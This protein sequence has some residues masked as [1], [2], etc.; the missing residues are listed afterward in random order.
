MVQ[1]SEVLPLLRSRGSST[2]PKE[3]RKSGFSFRVRAA[4]VSLGAASIL[5][6]VAS[7]LNRPE[8]QLEGSSSFS[9]FIVKYPQGNDASLSTGSNIPDWQ[10][11]MRVGSDP[12]SLVL[13]STSCIS[14][15]LPVLRGVDVV[16]YFSLKPGSAPVYGDS[17]IAYSLYKGFTFLFSSEH[18]KDLFEENPRKFS[19]A[20]GNFDAF[21]MAYEQEKW[22]NPA[23]GL[24]ATFDPDFWKIGSDG[25]LYV[26]ENLEKML[27]FSIDENSAIIRG[28]LFWTYATDNCPTCY[29]TACPASTVSKSVVS[30]TQ[31]S[32]SSIVSAIPDWQPVM[33]V[34]GIPISSILTSTACIDT[35]FPVLG[36]VDVVSYFNMK[37]GDAPI[38]GTFTSSMYKG[39]K[40]KFSSQKNKELFDANPARYVPAWGNFGSYGMAYEQDKWSNAN[41]RLGATF[42]PAVWKIGIDGRLYIF[43]NVKKMEQFSSNEKDAI[44]RGDLFWAYATDNCP[45]CFNTACPTL[46]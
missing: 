24:G 10:P 5:F 34:N 8:V 20:W 29:N 27:N 28:N 39:F 43:E 41:V 21:G 6:L 4:I 1:Q 40:F 26:F 12:I 14:T 33:R 9:K 3:S 13:T 44:I 11:A 35:Y 2:W 31:N 19:P 22:G 46:S 16:S 42:N 36:G 38:F 17:E 32:R 15:S 30:I 23:I 45:T 25:R 18:N 7:S 37:Q